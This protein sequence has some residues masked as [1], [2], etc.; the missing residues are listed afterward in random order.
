MVDTNSYLVVALRCLSSRCPVCP[1]LLLPL[2][3]AI[4]LSVGVGYCLFRAQSVRW[5]VLLPMQCVVSPCV[6]RA[7]ASADCGLFVCSCVCRAAAFAV[8]SVRAFVRAAAS[9]VCSLSVCC[10]ACAVCS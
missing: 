7:A 5:C 3:C 4:C 2:S 10:V 1:C 9:V 6:C 8:Q